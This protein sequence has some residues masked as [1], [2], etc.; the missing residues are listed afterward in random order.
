MRIA[1][2]NLLGYYVIVSRSGSGC[3]ARAGRAPLSLCLSVSPIVAG[4]VAWDPV[5]FEC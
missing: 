3:G 4:C 5:S 2:C 1:V